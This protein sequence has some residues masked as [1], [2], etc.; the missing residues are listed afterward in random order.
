MMTAILKSKK[1]CQDFLK[2]G[3]DGFTLTIVNI[4]N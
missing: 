3:I 1:E 2:N 4:V